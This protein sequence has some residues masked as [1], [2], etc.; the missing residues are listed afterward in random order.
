MIFYYIFIHGFLDTVLIWFVET[1]L[2]R[3]RESVVETSP[4]GNWES[5]ID[6]SNGTHCLIK[7]SNHKAKA[8][9][10]TYADILKSTK[11]HKQP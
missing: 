11:R 4:T 3:D 10:W 9:Q 2:T 8:A 1:I 7:I 6:M 5:L